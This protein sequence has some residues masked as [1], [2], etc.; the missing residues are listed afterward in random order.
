MAR[1]FV[2]NRSF[3]EQIKRTVSTLRDCPLKNIMNI[4]FILEYDILNQRE[5]FLLLR[6]V[7]NH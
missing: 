1:T 5:C 4:I 2:K 3:Q 7:L 6:R